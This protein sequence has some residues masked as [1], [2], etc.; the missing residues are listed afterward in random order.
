[1]AGGTRALGDAMGHTVPQVAAASAAIREFE[2]NLP[3]RAVERFLTTTLGMGPALQ[4]I[5]P[6]VGAIAFGAAIFEAGKHV[7]NMLGLWG[8]V[9]EAQ[10]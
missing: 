4:A 8:G 7:G 10:K 3:I 6:V 1:M 5:F 2:G 9:T